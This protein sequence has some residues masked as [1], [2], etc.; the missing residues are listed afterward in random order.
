V[1]LSGCDIEHELRLGRRATLLGVQHDP[2]SDLLTVTYRASAGNEPEVRLYDINGDCHLARVLPAAT[3]SEQTVQ[4][5][6][7]DAGRGFYLLELHDRAE[8]SILPLM[9]AR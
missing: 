8:H 2:A 5:A 7:P 4:I 3:D 1:L 6:I 9:I